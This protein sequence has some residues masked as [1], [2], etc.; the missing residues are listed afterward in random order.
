VK[1]TV[2]ADIVFF[3]FANKENAK[4]ILCHNEYDISKT[5][6]MTD[7]LQVLFKLS[8]NLDMLAN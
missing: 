1:E 2:A 5:G 6:N 4:S 8:V 7:I 3:Y